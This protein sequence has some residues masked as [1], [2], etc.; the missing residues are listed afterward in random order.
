MNSIKT[1]NKLKINLFGENRV[2]KRILLSEEE[3]DQFT[4][5]HS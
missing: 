2:L 5:A 1:L 4:K 3:I